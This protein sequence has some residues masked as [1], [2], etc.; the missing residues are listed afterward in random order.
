M[1]QNDADPAEI[2]AGT[3]PQAQQVNTDPLALYCTEAQALELLQRAKITPGRKIEPLRPLLRYIDGASG[4]AAD[5]LCRGTLTMITGQKGC[6]K[7]TLVRAL[8]AVLLNGKLQGSESPE[9]ITARAAGLKIAVIDT[10]QHESRVQNSSNW[11]Q[12][13]YRQPQPFEE[14][15]EYYSGRGLNTDSLRDL[16]I[17]ICEHSRPDVLFLDVISHFVDDINDQKAAK[18]M[19]DFVNQICERYGVA[20]VGIIHQN[21]NKEA[22]A[23][24]KMAGAL[25]TKLLQAAEAVL[26]VARAQEGLQE[27]DADKN[28][29]GFLYGR[30]SVVTFAEYRERWPDITT[31]LLRNENERG[32][33]E[34]SMQP[35]EIKNE[36]EKPGLPKVLRAFIQPARIVA[37]VAADIARAE[38]AALSPSLELTEQTPAAE[39]A[40]D[41]EQVNSPGGLTLE[42]YNAVLQQK[43]PLEAGAD[44]EQEKD[45]LPF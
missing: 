17:T 9:T 37:Q 5:F 33:Y 29:R 38:A 7:S 40:A 20:V 42:Q 45:D 10:E 23:A 35:V 25:G 15:C 39:P 21:P 28:P 8:C 43:N 44:G 4:R 24:D 16:C 6:R 41:G 13:I 11:L 2:G 1:L 26:H 12:S 22:T 18:F 36:Q 27:V 19:V 32:A 34:L 14:R 3:E 30:A 31:I